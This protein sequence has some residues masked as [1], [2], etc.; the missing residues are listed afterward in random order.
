MREDYFIDLI[1]P[2]LRTNKYGFCGYLND[3]FLSTNN[4]YFNNVI[5]NFIKEYGNFTPKN[6]GF[7]YWFKPS[8]ILPR[9]ILLNKT[10]RNF[11]RL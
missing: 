9:L 7:E 8:A 4:S 11:N 2:F 5:L 6:K 1:F 10:I 3:H